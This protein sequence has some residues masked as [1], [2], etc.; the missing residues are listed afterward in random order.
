MSAVL[1]LSVQATTATPAT[2]AEQALA[3]HSSAVTT[4]SGIWAALPTQA[5]SAPYVRSALALTFAVAVVTPR[6]QYFWV[7]NTGTLSL[8]GASYTVTETGSP[9]I[10]ATVEAC[11]GGSWNESTDACSGTVTTVATSG[12]GAMSSSVVSA[13]PSAQVRLRARVSGPPTVT[14]AVVT[15]SISVARGNARAAA[16]TDS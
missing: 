1:V 2:A 4:S 16:T 13:A 8:T 12:G 11:V 10:S 3:R 6:P 14:A 5:A 7:V 9:G 15:T